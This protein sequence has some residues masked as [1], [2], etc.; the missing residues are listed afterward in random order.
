MT[1]SETPRQKALTWWRT[2]VEQGRYVVKASDGPSLSATRYLLQEG[3]VVEVAGG[4]VWILA[5]PG[6]E[7]PQ[8]LCLT[9]F[10]SIVGVVIDD[11]SPAVI[12]G[13]SAVR[14]HLEDP[15]PPSVLTV[16][17]AKNQSKYDIQVCEDQIV[18]LAPGPVDEG[19]LM[20]RTLRGVDLPAEG[21]EHTLFRLPLS[22]LEDHLEDVTIWLRSLV[23]SPRELRSAYQKNPRPLVAKRM[24][25]LAEDVG[26]DR[27]AQQ[28]DDLLTAEYGQRITRERTGVGRRVVVPNHVTEVPRTQTP[29]LDRH[30]STLARMQRE[31]KEALEER[32]REL[33][34]FPLEKL[35]EHARA[36]KSY[37]A[38]HST[39][40]EGYRISPEEVSAVLR[41]ELVAGQDPEEVRSRMAIT[42]Y[43]A[44][45]ERCLEAVQDQEGRMRFSEALISDLYVDL[46]SPAV[47]AGIIAAEDLR[48]YRSE[49][50][51]LRGH[52]HIPPSPRKVPALMTQFIE[53]INQVS[54]AP[55]IRATL[56]HLD[57]V[58][59]HP[60]PDGNGRIARFLMN[61]ALLGEGLPWVTIRNDDRPD[62]FR[63]LEKA[64]IEGDFRPFG[65]FV[66]GYV[67]AATKEL[68][69]LA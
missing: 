49:R 10:W 46:F 15:T 38:Y 58:T 28:I 12:E 19:D 26:N 6:R 41:D 5:V 11:Y 40:I 32:E 1:P 50:A 48:G 7:E 22:V 57:F 4:R 52:A 34:R 44:A 30:G 27:L 45:F 16:R 39:T 54:G 64:Q 42:G 35:K 59:I 20:L 37:D 31:L 43:G 47:D 68:T 67:V 17:H 24:A 66:A 62:Y 65:S 21:P 69:N 51:Y 13:G 2:Q 36:A 14:V 23:I 53:R 9:H 8:D 25:H 55:L 61:L 63:F 3:H 18:R 29:W 33:P 60:F 56:A